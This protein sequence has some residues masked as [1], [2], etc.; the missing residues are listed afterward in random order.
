MFKREN[1]IQ[2]IMTE[3][4]IHIKVGN[5]EIGYEGSEEYIRNDL[6]STVK[7]VKDMFG[8]DEIPQIPTETQM[9][10]QPPQPTGKQIQGTVANISAKLGVKNG[11]ELVMATAA[12]L[13]MVE[14]CGQF[15]RKQ[16]ID[17]MKT[18][19]SYF[20]AS[21]VSNLS[22]HLNNLVK[23]GM[24]NEVAKDTYAL[25]VSSITEMESKL[26]C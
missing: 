13:T 10:V 6:L 8:I 26:A 5:L 24:I 15:T 21:Y 9:Q 7:K 4:K 20:K 23:K 14:Q 3:G 1:S 12:Y 19:S 18:A 16:I 2:I 25:P 17:N 11:P 22:Q